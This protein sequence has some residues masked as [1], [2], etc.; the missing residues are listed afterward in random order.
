MPADAFT[1]RAFVAF[2]DI[3][4]QELA[5]LDSDR[6]SSIPALA[7]PASF[8]MGSPPLVVAGAKTEQK[9]LSRTHADGVTTKHT[10]HTK[11]RRRHRTSNARPRLTVQ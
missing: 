1:K 7:V 10:K 2:L 4:T 11:F 5:V 9:I 3:T 8:V 6:D